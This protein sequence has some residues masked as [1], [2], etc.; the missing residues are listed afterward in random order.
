MLNAG[1]VLFIVRWLPRGFLVIGLACYVV[2]A[3]IVFDTVKFLLDTE[4]TKGV[5]LEITPGE[6]RDAPPGTEVAYDFEGQRVVFEWPLAPFGPEAG[7]FVDVLYDP[8]DPENA[9]VDGFMSL[10]FIPA[11]LGVFGGGFLA[12]ARMGLRLPKSLDDS[13]QEE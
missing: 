10:W 13:D 4:T 8:G 7:D 2:S 12:F 9:R 3:V 6:G 1:P 5:V 11:L